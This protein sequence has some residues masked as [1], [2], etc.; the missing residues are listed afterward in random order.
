M[1]YNYFILL[2]ITHPPSPR[3]GNIVYLFKIMS[4]QFFKAKPLNESKDN[5]PPFPPREPRK[6]YNKKYEEK[7]A[8]Q[9]DARDHVKELLNAYKVAEKPTQVILALQKNFPKFFNQHP[10]KPEPETS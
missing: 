7:A 2:A 6:N 10:K 8:L 9:K 5:K 3:F 4:K 1:T